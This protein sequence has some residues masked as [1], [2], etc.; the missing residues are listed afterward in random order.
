GTLK[1]I[2][3]DSVD[4]YGSYIEGSTIV[5]RKNDDDYVEM[6]GST[7]YS[8]GLHDR[9]WFGETG[10]DQVQIGFEN[11]QL[12]ARNHTQEWSLFF[13]DYGI[14]TFSDG[15]GTGYPGGNASG[16]IEFHSYKYYG[17]QFRGLTIM[18]YGLTAIESSN[19]NGA[20]IY[21]N[22]IVDCMSELAYV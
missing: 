14:S 20:R 22:Q 6:K 5:S 12:R 17:G 10:T 3:I 18:S 21:L 19:E 11:G 15:D 1:S 8:H 9:T 2:M 16:A 4:I 13:N 7:L